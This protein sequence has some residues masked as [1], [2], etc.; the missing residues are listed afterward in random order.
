VGDEE[1]VNLL[2]SAALL[3]LPLRVSATN[4]AVLEALACGWR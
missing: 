1:Y 4:T 3:V 2:R